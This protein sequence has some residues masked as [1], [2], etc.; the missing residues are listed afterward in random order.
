[1][2]EIV[3][4]HIF[5]YLLISFLIL[6]TMF[7]ESSIAQSAEQKSD[8]SESKTKAT[9]KPRRKRILYLHASW[10]TFC[11]RVKRESYPKLKKAKWK[12][13][14]KASN[15]IQEID[16]DKFP[17]L[18]DKYDLELLPTF[19]LI[20]DGK[21]VNRRDGYLSAYKISELYHGRLKKKKEE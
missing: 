16:T 18:I 11:Q 3:R 13:G 10:C 20:V 9:E 6:G 14:P 12:I 15:H 5:G 17:K 19:I 8:S 2:I 21:E 7:Q 4:L 1:M